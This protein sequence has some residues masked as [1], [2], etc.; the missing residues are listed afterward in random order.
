[1]A[2]NKD[3]MNI[4]YLPNELKEQIL[5]DLSDDDLIKQTTIP[6]LRYVAIELLK[7]KLN[8]LSIKNLVL[9]YKFKDLKIAVGQYYYEC[10]LLLKYKRIK[11]IY[12][13]ETEPMIREA[14]KARIGEQFVLLFEQPIPEHFNILQQ[15]DK[16][17]SMLFTNAFIRTVETNGGPFNGFAAMG[18]QETRY[19]TTGVINMKHIRPDGIIGHSY[20][21][22]IK[23]GFTPNM[24]RLL[25]GHTVEGDIDCEYNAI[26]QRL[27][28]SIIT[29]YTFDDIN[30]YTES[31][32]NNSMGPKNIVYSD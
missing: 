8:T 5:A 13:N 1:M 27:C 2:S 32:G 7:K 4:Q 14:I 21:L 6:G 9:L 26:F 28:E 25:R 22:E 17:R 3:E 12:Q 29:N 11:E 23:I 18:R 16:I 24:C 20:S 19:M 10:L 15:I 30:I 31:I